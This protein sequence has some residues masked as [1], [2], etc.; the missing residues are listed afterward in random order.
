LEEGGGITSSFFTETLGL[1]AAPLSVDDEQHDD[2]DDDEGLGKGK[3]KAGTDATLNL[4]A[5]IDEFERED[6]ASTDEGISHSTL[7]GEAPPPPQTNG[8]SE[9]VS[10]QPQLKSVPLGDKASPAVEAE[11]LMDTS[12]DPLLKA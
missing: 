2:D 12:E 4:K 1:G 3:G 10:P 6:E 5:K 11:G 8:V 7:Q 9:V